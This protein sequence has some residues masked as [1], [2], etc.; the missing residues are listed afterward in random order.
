VGIMLDTGR[1][2]G[3]AAFGLSFTPS[4]AASAFAVK[5]SS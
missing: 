3:R 4:F 1:A 2:P 5:S